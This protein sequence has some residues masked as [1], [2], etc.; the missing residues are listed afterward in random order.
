MKYERDMERKSKATIKSTE[1]PMNSTWEIT[2]TKLREDS[3][4]I[5]VSE[6]Q[7]IIETSSAY[8]PFRDIFMINNRLLLYSES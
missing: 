5:T 1:E 3:E 4:G 2:S 7:T 8:H 6:G